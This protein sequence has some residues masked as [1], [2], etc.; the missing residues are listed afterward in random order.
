MMQGTCYAEPDTP[1]KIVLVDARD[2]KEVRRFPLEGVNACNR[3]IDCSS[4]T[5]GGGGTLLFLAHKDGSVWVHG[6]SN[7]AQIAALHGHASG[8]G[9]SGHHRLLPACVCRSRDGEYLYVATTDGQ[10]VHRF[11]VGVPGTWTRKT[12]A[13]FPQAFKAAAREL[14]LC[15]RASYARGGGDAD[16]SG[17]GAAA[18]PGTGFD[19]ASAP[20]ARGAIFSSGCARTPSLW[21][22]G[23]ARLVSVEPAILELVVARMARLAHGCR[24]GDGLGS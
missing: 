23:F 24:V 4:L 9:V 5:S 3:F 1:L 7:G 17:H 11:S 8:P 16:W 10:R 13:R 2:G 19:I 18:D 12:H 15:A 14:A 22:E 6:A 20:S 21:G